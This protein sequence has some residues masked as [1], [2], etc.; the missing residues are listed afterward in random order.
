MP[1]SARTW[2]SQTCVRFWLNETL[3]LPRL[4]MIALYRSRTAGRRWLLPARH[5]VESPGFI[6][7]LSGR[8]KAHTP[9]FVIKKGV[10][11]CSMV[12]LR[13]HVSRHFLS[14]SKVPPPARALCLRVRPHCNAVCMLQLD[15]EL[16][17]DTTTYLANSDF[18]SMCHLEHVGGAC[19]FRFNCKGTEACKLRGMAALHTCT[20]VLNKYF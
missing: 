20:C 10:N 9:S 6:P 15:P 4:A 16:S 1:G 18:V 2:Y 5:V 14:A 8:E 17:S 13:N 19:C 7:A 12:F 3:F 11:G